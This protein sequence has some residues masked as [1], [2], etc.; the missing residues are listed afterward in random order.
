MKL[1]LCVAV[2]QS[3]RV[4]W[5]SKGTGLLWVLEPTVAQPPQRR[6]RRPLCGM[7]ISHKVFFNCLKVANA[8][9]YHSASREPQLLFPCH[10]MDSVAT[11]L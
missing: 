6:C 11:M 9:S 8:D 5:P 3:Q 2:L 7:G 1:D 4:L 10:R